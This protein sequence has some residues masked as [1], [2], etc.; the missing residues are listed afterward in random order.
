[1]KELHLNKHLTRHRVEHREHRVK[2][3]NDTSGIM[4]GGNWKL[5]IGY[6]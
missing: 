1:M 2:P 6:W 5:V 4:A 3:Q